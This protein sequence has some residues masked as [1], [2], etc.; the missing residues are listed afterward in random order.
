[1][2]KWFKNLTKG[3]LA[4]GVLALCLLVF[5]GYFGYHKLVVKANSMPN[6]AV[7]NTLAEYNAMCDSGKVDLTQE[8][9]DKDNPFLILEIVPYYGQAEVGY[10]ISGCEPMDFSSFGDGVY[11]GASNSLHTIAT[12]VF[13]DEYDRDHA[14]YEEG[15]YIDETKWTQGDWYINSNDEIEVH[16]YYERVSN[17]QTGDFVIDHYEQDTTGAFYTKDADGKDIAAYRPIFRKAKDGETGQFNWTTLYYQKGFLGCMSDEQFDAYAQ[18]ENKYVSSP[19][20]TLTY[21]PGEREY[22]T[23]KDTN[24]M[25][26]S[27]STNQAG[28]KIANGGVQWDNYDEGVSAVRGHGFND[29]HFIRTSLNLDDKSE[30]A[31]RNLKIAV[32]TV[33]PQEL[34]KHPE[35]IDY[36]D[37]MYIHQ[38]VSVGVY[39][40]W[41]QNEKLDKYRRV[42]DELNESYYKDDPDIRQKGSDIQFTAGNDWGWNVAKK[43]FFKINQIGDYDE[44]SFAPLIFSVTALDNIKSLISST[45]DSYW[46]QVNHYHLDYTT[47][48]SDADNPK[49][50]YS[51][52]GANFGIY[53][54]M[55]M[56]FLMDA[57]NFY[58]FFFQTERDS[59]GTVIT[60]DLSKDTSY[61]TPQKGAEAQEY[62]SVDAFLPITEKV[63]DSNLSDA[64]RERYSI[65]FNQAYLNM[66]RP[67]VFGATFIYNSTSLMS[68]QFKDED[69]LKESEYTKDAFDWWEKEYG[70]R[71][72]SLSPAQMVHYLLQYKRHGNDDDDV[73]TRDK[74]TMHVLE[75]EPCA[76]YFITEKYLVG[77]YLPA[78]RFQG[79]IEVDHMTT[80]EFNGLRRD[81][82]GY[83]DLI[84]IGDN[85]GKFNTKTTQNNGVS[86]EKTD[87]NDSS[88]NQ[89]VYLHV[90]DKADKNGKLR[91]SGDDISK[92]K[93]VQ[94]QKYAQGG[95]AL[96][97]A[98]SLATFKV[99]NDNNITDAYKNNYLTIVDTS[100]QMHALLES[101]KSKNEGVAAFKKK[102]VCAL[103]KLSVS[104]LSKNC[105]KYMNKGY[106]LPARTKTS[107][108][109]R[110]YKE[111]VKK[112]KNELKYEGLYS[113]ITGT[114][115]R[116]YDSDGMKDDEEL[117]ESTGAKQSLPGS[118]LDFKFRIGDPS[119]SYAV[120][121]YIDL[122]GDGVIS[123]DELVQ[124]TFANK[125]GS[126]Y[127]YTG[128]AAVDNS[129]PANVYT[130]KNGDAITVPGE[131]TYSY[132]F[133]NNKRLYL[134]KTRK[135]G[136]ITW[137]F[138]LY[139]TKS[140]E[141]YQSV[142]GTSRYGR[143][144]KDTTKTQE[145]TNKTLIKA[146]QIV[147]DDQLNTQAN[148]QNQLDNGG[149]FKT[150][151]DKLDD[152][153]VQVT[154]VGM[155]DFLSQITAGTLGG[156]NAGE[157]YNCYIV[158]C[159]SKIF[160]NADNKD[161][162]GYLVGRAKA[163]VSMIFTG[164]A[165][166]SK[167]QSADAKD[168]LNMSRYTDALQLYGDNNDKATSP[169]E[170]EYEDT[171]KMEYTY[172]KV[173]EQGSDD[174]K[175]KVYRN[176]LW[177][178]VKYGD[179]ASKTTAVCR[180]NKGRYTTYPYT[181][182]KTI[183]VSGVSA[184]DYQLNMNSDAL[185]VWYS[186]GPDGDGDDTQYGISPRDAS[187][188][189]YLYSI[190]NVVYDLIDL[191][192]VSDATEMKL[193][194]NTLSGNAVSPQVTV[195]SGKTVD[196][197][198]KDLK[199]SEETDQ[200][201]TLD[202][203]GTK[204]SEDGS[205]MTV[206]RGVIEPNGSNYR[207]YKQGSKSVNG[208][209]NGNGGKIDQT[210]PTAVPATPTPVPTKQPK[211][212]AYGQVYNYQTGESNTKSQDLKGWSNDAILVVEYKQTSQWD[213]PNDGATIGGIK[214]LDGNMVQEIKY[215]KSTMN[216][217]ISIGDLKT[218][219]GIA[220]SE[221]L[222][223]M[224]IECWQW[225]HTFSFIG[226]FNSEDQYQQYKDGKI[227]FDS[228]DAGGDD[229]G[230]TGESIIEND[231]KKY[232]DHDVIVDRTAKRNLIPDTATHRISFTPYTN[233]TDCV[234][235]NSFKISMITSGG[236]NLGTSA[237][238]TFDYVD[239]IFQKVTLDTPVN[240]ELTAVWRYKASK[241]HTFTI[242]NNNFLRDRSQYY[243]FTDDTMINTTTSSDADTTRWFRFDISNRRKSAISYLH[244]Y[245]EGNVDTT[246]V[247]DLD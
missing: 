119:G 182:D 172:S 54:F 148:L 47:M 4:I 246:Y 211:R 32:K 139:N 21:K 140:E 185:A 29:N 51:T 221:D 181:I 171:S 75:I 9:G 116:W 18:E 130:D 33:E 108:N 13:K 103:S 64:Q 132:D 20:E 162:A 111:F 186:L 206:Y 176:S 5:G 183:N 113:R 109:V 85:I 135:S 49:H 198:Y 65:Y 60:E 124:D 205:D 89:Y 112:Y 152:Y 188:N 48:E 215:N 66:P 168:T 224:K 200:Y 31:I 81:I 190:D 28:E 158:S 115:L 61:C 173:M 169:K 101:L 62:W 225:G 63:N 235:V 117:N 245:Y 199:I 217:E 203:D 84:Y 58:K 80:A 90:G 53:K 126:T 170:E 238:K 24:Y 141:N 104:F 226:I 178:N 30:Q 136:A 150:Y 184:Q 38:G 175:N 131:Q 129:K 223:S 35:W 45:S 7:V 55:L 244:L 234:N 134:N 10:L 239:E 160:G 179:A 220:S 123:D 11:S 94:L 102:N 96:V 92:V 192:N 242:K 14:L 193:F 157:D 204:K 15:K 166:N 79:K 57:D 138:V 39:T 128:E 16:G 201:F 149:L 127:V 240:G 98:D 110:K 154:T 6:K 93:K 213:N 19:D 78:S 232:G 189:Y 237:E 230:D 105:L 202:A 155:S 70:E 34:K 227:D 72:K 23:R 137:K 187:N 156:A 121:L 17:G 147:A 1:M 210:D 194:I 97:L 2:K 107:L 133:S 26:M 52:S 216:Y 228:M 25:S 73:G 125:S 95:N 50:T 153:T 76:D 3:K 77:T 99:D 219:Y 8:A 83:Y 207:D 56:N 164:E 243:F 177:K 174:N 142:T 114:P 247:F 191:E 143:D 106:Q 87:Y 88:L 146:F 159:G 180:N 68:Q 43:L 74:E 22:T 165:I 120:K 41:W 122:N 233:A 197:N 37:L 212:L 42:K 222:P 27:Y 231:D 82:N 12:A 161:A 209:T 36:A 208:S 71:P 46:K 40:K 241:D 86:S 196:S 163:G 151:T 145:N 218:K 229:G 44:F 100:S 59:G 236:S 67:S 118:T 69:R 144:N 214:K 91:S 195:D 167:T